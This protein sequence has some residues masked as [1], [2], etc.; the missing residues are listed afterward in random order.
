MCCLNQM[1]M[2]GWFARLG[3]LTGDVIEQRWILTG[4]RQV[5]GRT[6]KT[7]DPSVGGDG[8]E[9]VSARWNDIDVCYEMNGTIGL[10][11]GSLGLSRPF[12]RR[13]KS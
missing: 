6:A 5:D 9:S 10:V 3:P 11:T 4:F 1:D 8:D 7:D 2:T 12:G 13:L